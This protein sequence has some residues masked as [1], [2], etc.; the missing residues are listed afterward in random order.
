MDTIGDNCITVQRSVVALHTYPPPVTPLAQ[1]SHHLRL[2][3][4]FC[5]HVC[6]LL[7]LQLVHV[8]VSVVYVRWDVFN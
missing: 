3:P 8:C 2:L 1:L 6:V 4:E 5:A 7:L